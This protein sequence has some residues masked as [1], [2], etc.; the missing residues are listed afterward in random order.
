MR[1]APLAALLL[2]LAACDSKPSVPIPGARPAQP[3]AAPGANAPAAGSSDVPKGETTYYFGVRE[4]HTNITFQSKNDLTDILGASHHATGSATI[5]F[6]AG[7]GKLLSKVSEGPKA[8]ASEAAADRAA[9][10]VK[11]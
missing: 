8:Q 6:D 7:T 10:K 2:L 5:N 1:I 4:T 9:S 3:P 11:K